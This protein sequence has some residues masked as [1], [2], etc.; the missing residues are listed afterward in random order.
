MDKK[1]LNKVVDQLVRETKVDH[2]RDKIYFPFDTLT[3][4]S[5][6]SEHPFNKHCREVY[7][8]NEK[9]IEWV[10]GKYK[11]HIYNKIGNG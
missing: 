2:K 5:S 8:L 1:F 11:T 7:G 4:P 9:E 3:N 6:L 10:W